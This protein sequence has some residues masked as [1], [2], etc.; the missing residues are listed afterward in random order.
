M[1]LLSVLILFIPMSAY[2]ESL[3]V[4][5]NKDIY[6][7]DEKAIIVGAIPADAPAGYAVLIKVTGPRGECAV[8]NILS[9]ADN[10]FVSR[11]VR[12]DECGIGGFAVSAYYSAEEATSTFTISSSSHVSAG[13]EMEL[14]MLKNI[15]LQAQDTANARVKQLIGD[16]YFL[17]EMAAKKYGEGVSEASLALQAIEFGDSTEAKKHM[18]F[19]FRDFREVLDALSDENVA[20]FQQSAG[21]Q[22]SSSDKSDIA[23]KYDSLKEY[24][25]RLEQ[26]AEK[27][28][29]DK[30]GIEDAGLLL[31]NAK[32]M[33][34][35]DN[36]EGAGRNLGRVNA[37]LEEIRTSLFDKEAGEKLSSNTNTTSGVD[38][39]LK[40]KL[41]DTADR[42]ERV[43]LKLLNET[44]SD[45]E[46]EAKV[47][48]AISLLAN[49]KASI[50]AQDL[51]S[52]REALSAA[53]KAINEA[54]ELLKG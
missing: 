17:P 25:F 16:G 52:A 8:Q 47:H 46:A 18:I 48:N 6:T 44:G 21:Q 10:S 51:E 22:A 42:F 4:T 2:A 26:L 33:I 1:S 36:F 29:V 12:L 15:V 35:D 39:E 30:S 50:H 13:R 32:R 9:A 3:T 37:L 28:K 31:A 54:R 40:R 23:G 19:A 49:A 27:N 43:A 24:Y 41:T 53:Y 20:G 14:R 34:D 11:P 5:T 38:E 7:N 45:T